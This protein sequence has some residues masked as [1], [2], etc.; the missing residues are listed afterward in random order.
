MNVVKLVKVTC[1]FC[2]V[3][4]LSGSRYCKLSGVELASKDMGNEFGRELGRP[5]YDDFLS[6]S[7]L[8]KWD[9]EKL[10]ELVKNKSTVAVEVANFKDKENPEKWV[11]VPVGLSLVGDFDI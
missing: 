5:V 9:D 3:S 8:E 11:S 1:V 7:I 2:G 10:F 6:K 4:K